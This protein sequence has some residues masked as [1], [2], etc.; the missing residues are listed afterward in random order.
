MFGLYYETWNR[1]LSTSNAEQNREDVSPAAQSA[2]P[3]SA[4]IPNPVHSELRQNP[5]EGGSAL[6]LPQPVPPSGSNI[7]GKKRK[8]TPV[9]SD[10][11]ELPAEPKPKRR[12]RRRQNILFLSDSETNNEAEVEP[13]PP[14]NEPEDPTPIPPCEDHT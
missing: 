7:R 6:L 10:K 5:S 14:P 11:E 9:I 8:K 3:A 1:V 13:D 12:R 2:G 4:T